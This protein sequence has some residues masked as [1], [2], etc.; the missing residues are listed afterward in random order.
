MIHVSVGEEDQVDAREV[1]GIEG[2]AND[3]FAADCGDAELGADAVKKY[4]VSKNVNPEEVKE[5]GGVTDPADV[6]GFVGP[7]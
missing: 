1:I 4:R 2:G 6:D 3:A 7:G 5:N